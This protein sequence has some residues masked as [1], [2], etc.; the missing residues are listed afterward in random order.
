MLSA[1]GA[2][3]TM[4]AFSQVGDLEELCILRKSLLLRSIKFFKKAN[5]L[6]ESTIK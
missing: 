5:K 4:N 6:L 1:K 3:S 2:D